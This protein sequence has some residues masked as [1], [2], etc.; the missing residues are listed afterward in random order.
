MASRRWLFALVPVAAIVVA[1]LTQPRLVRTLIDGPGVAAGIGA[2]LGCAGVFVMGR[3]PE[4]VLAQDLIPTDPLLARVTLAVDRARQSV[5]GKFLGLVA[6][7]AFYRPGLGCTMV[8]GIDETGL[9]AQTAGL[10]PM[11]PA[12]R[13]EPWPQGDAVDLTHRPAAIDGAALDA[14]MAGAFAET[15]LGGK[16]DTR[17]VI[18]TWR[19]RIVAERYAD[20]FDKDTRLLGWSMGKSITSALI[21]TL[22]A[23]GRLALDAPPPVP[24]FRQATDGRAAI[25]LKQLLQMRSGLAFTETYGPG[26]DSTEM[27]FGQDD[28]AH[29]AATRPLIH[30]PGSVWSY[31]SGTANILA[32]LV[33]DAAGGDLVHEY[34]YMRS[35]LFEP[36]GMTSALVEPDGIG[37]V[38]GSSY[39]YM[40]ARDWARF[41]QLYL[42]AGEINGQRLLP[43]DWVGFSHEG[44][45]PIDEPGGYGAQFWLNS[46]G[47]TPAR[48]RWPHCPPE[49][50][51]ALGHNDEIVAIVPSRQL[52]FVR[53]GWTTGGA[54][55]DADTH[56]SDILASIHDEP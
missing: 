10:S 8:N 14:A 36:A 25:T 47:G 30:S 33:F 4:T 23:D 24:A 51:M 54:R 46:D 41:G 20:G 26:D 15:S 37:S 5:T 16:I 19:G 7:T 18:V 52:V 50:Y 43:A 27:L 34:D 28:M 48:L 12:P 9:R 3:S 49:T 45:G 13:P 38:V 21:G 1:A 32:H 44:G 31:S 42:G 56:L 53:L 29:Y 22:V 17:A 6:R 55:F 11:Q 40:T 35:H 2:E 39:P